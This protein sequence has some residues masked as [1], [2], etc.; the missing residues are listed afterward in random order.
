MFR[1]LSFFL[2]LATTISISRFPFGK[3][4]VFLTGPISIAFTFYL[5]LLHSVGS[6]GNFDVN[7]D[8]S[9]PAAGNRAV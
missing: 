9:F 3:H 6:D 1:L 4:R 7:S 8:T 2:T 5:W